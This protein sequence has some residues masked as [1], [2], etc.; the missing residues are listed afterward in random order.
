MCH[1]KIWIS[2]IVIVTHCDAHPVSDM[3]QAGL[4][5]HIHELQLAGFLQHV[6]EQAIPRLPFGGGR[7]ARIAWTLAWFKNSALHQKNIQISVSVVVDEGNPG[8]HDFGQVE[9]PG[10]S[11][12]M[13][14]LKP[15]L[16]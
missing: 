15:G 4:F 2:I 7:E 10:C 13:L 8:S 5:G 9:L 14:K 16:S 6:A 12:E 11:G 1:V 3:T